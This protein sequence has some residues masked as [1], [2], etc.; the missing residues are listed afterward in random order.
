MDPQS[1]DEPSGRAGEKAEP[2]QY[3][4]DCLHFKG[5]VPCTPHKERGVHCADCPE[6]RRRA[7]RI[8]LI[9]LGAAGDV[10]RTTPLLDPLKRNYPDH[11]LTWVTDFP[12]L[13]P[14]VVDDRLRWDTNAVLLLRHTPFD[15]VI[16][17]D[18]DRQA[19][20]LAREVN[21]DRKLGFV[22]G[23][24]GICRPV[25]DGL[26]EGM[27][28]A[29]VH[30]FLTGLFDDV[31]QACT[32]SY[33]QEIFAICGYEF[34]GQEYVLDRPAVAPVFELPSGR[35][36]VGLNTGCG[37]RWTSRLW[38]ERYWED[39]AG[40]LQASGHAV[41]LLGGP[42]EDE[43]NRRLARATGAC[44]PGHFD[45]QTFIGLMDRCDLVV[46]AVTMGMHIALGLGKKLVLL[47]NIFNPHEF[48]LYG[49]GA[50]LAPQQAC[51]CFFSP[52][53]RNE[54]FCLETLLPDAVEQAVAEL[55][56]TS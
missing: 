24:D 7:G 20:A 25:T 45:L 21:A 9:K 51:T 32:L 48:E 19:C 43:K 29:A 53:C 38:P 30:K 35:S 11:V 1:N 36:T 10:I 50:I 34:Q 40:K 41:V 22:L 3:R 49:R 14:A 8:L 39:L 55:L 5:H 23:D 15:L 54:S 37:G 28:A 33:L 2:V 16:N 52:R 18:K 4:P 12:D 56:E 6:Y 27:A 26:S 13:L 31:N 47:N 42:Q 46:S 44:Y 17:L